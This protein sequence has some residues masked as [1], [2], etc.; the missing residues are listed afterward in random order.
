[1]S[2]IA[3]AAD[4]RPIPVADPLVIHDIEFLGGMAEAGGWRPSSGMPEIAFSGRSNVGKSSLLNRLV[5][6]KALARVSQTPGKT[7]E[8]NF[9]RI[10]DIFV[11]VDLPG[12][13][14][15]RV[16]KG[17][18]ELWRPLIEGYLKDSPELRGVVQLVDARHSPSVDDVQ[19]LDFLSELGVPAIVVA[20]KIDKLPRKERGTRIGEIARE[21]AVED[22][23]LLP[24]SAETGEGRDELASALV[25]LLGQPS[26]RSP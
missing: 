21:L 10:N 14:Y 4:E 16:S 23:Q 15:A 13:G 20:T 2:G 19:M 18:R 7:R 25:A 12:Y 1:M 17:R 5:R 11:L 3:P 6:R 26:W 9:F 8:I 22:E 24:F